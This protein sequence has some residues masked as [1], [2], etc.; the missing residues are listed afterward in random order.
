MTGALTVAQNDLRHFVAANPSSNARFAYL[1][2]RDITNHTAANLEFSNT[3][4]AWQ[5]TEDMSNWVQYNILHTGNMNLITPA[6]I[7]AAPKSAGT[8]TD[9]DLLAWAKAQT[10]SVC[11]FYMSSTTTTNIPSNYAGYAYV[12]VSGAGGWSI[13]CFVPATRKVYW[14]TTS[15]GTWVGWYEIAQLTNGA[16]P[17]SQGGTGA[18]TLTSGRAL[19]GAGTSAVTFRAITNNTA[20]SSAITG[21]TNLV[22]MNTLKNAINRTTSVAAADTNYTTLMAR[23]STLNAT[24]TTPTVNGAIAWTY[25]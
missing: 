14:N 24:E 12:F 22:T 15:S 5:V 17:V 13:M 4:L 2:F 8:I 10:A 21:S 23:G 25:E 6:A 16:L 1:Q 3:Q 20:T 11:G 9:T 18:T 7:G 19:I